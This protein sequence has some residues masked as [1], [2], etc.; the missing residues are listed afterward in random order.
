MA[1]H[2]KIISRAEYIKMTSFVSWQMRDVV[3]NLYHI[4]RFE[5]SRDR[6]GRLFYEPERYAEYRRCYRAAVIAV[7]AA[8]RH[9]A[10]QGV[11]SALYLF[12]C[13]RQCRATVEGVSLPA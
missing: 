10:N 8:I 5:T 12:V 7:S 6:W 11:P 4:K 2:A 3:R 1:L 9:L 13:T